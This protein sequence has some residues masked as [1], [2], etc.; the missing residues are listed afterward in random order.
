MIVFPAY[1][2]RVRVANA[3]LGT[4]TAPAVMYVMMHDT[5][6]L[7]RARVLEGQAEVDELRAVLLTD[8]WTKTIPFPHDPLLS[9]LFE[10]VRKMESR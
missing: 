5:A 9:G 1:C 4:P 7:E 6:P 2:N 8:E 10:F 3:Y